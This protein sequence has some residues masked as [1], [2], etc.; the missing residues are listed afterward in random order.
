MRVFSVFESS[1]K[2]GALEF[3][4]ERH[5]L[6]HRSET[7]GRRIDLRLRLARQLDR[8]GVA[9]ALEIEDSVAAPPMLVVADER[10]VR[11]GGECRL[12]GA[13]EA[14]EDRR[15]AVLAGVG[16]AMHR[17][18]LFRRQQIVEDG[19]HRFLHLARIAR[20]ADQ[21]DLAREV[22]GDDRLAS[23]AVP[24]GVGAERGQIDN[25]QLRNKVRQIFDR[26]TDQEIADEQRMPGVFGEDARAYAQPGIGASVKILSEKGLVSGV[27]D[28]VG[29]ER[30]EVLDRHRIV[31][32]PP[33]IGLGVRVAH[34]ELVLGAASGMRAQCQR[35]GRHARRYALR[36][37]AARARKVAARR[38]S[39]ESRQDRGSRTGPRRSRDYAFRSRSCRKRPPN[40]APQMYCSA[41]PSNFCPTVNPAISWMRQPASVSSACHADGASLGF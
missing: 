34:H 40:G 37:L 18:D 2:S 24:L 11:I 39:S 9:A 14:E 4:I 35:Q 21:H 36:C 41:N 27:S 28:E 26:R 20:A 7:F 12:A 22:A 32:V 17:H 6:H 3:R 13:G 38:G 16:R 19:E 25:R 30:V 31:V 23:R 1:S 33:D 10:A 29:E 5:V 8:L 15:V